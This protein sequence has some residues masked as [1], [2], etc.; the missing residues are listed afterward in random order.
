MIVNKIKLRSIL[1]SKDPIFCLKLTHH[2]VRTNMEQ[3]C[4]S[5]LAELDNIS[6]KVVVYFSL[7]QTATVIYI[8]EQL[9]ERYD[10]S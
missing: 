7:V 10:M 8:T 4:T 5:T 9:W 2:P 1:H 6:H 3:K